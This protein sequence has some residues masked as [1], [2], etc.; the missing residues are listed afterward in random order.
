KDEEIIFSIGLSEIKTKK[1]KDLFISEMKRRTPRNNFENCL[2]NSAKQFIVKKGESTEVIAG[3]HWF[4]SW[5]RDTFIALP[6]LTLSTFQPEKFK[7][8]IDSMLH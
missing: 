4:G 1:L 6:G 2:L 3:Y 5:G 7:A 8:V